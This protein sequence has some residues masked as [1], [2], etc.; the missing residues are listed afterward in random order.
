MMDYGRKEEVCKCGWGKFRREILKELLLEYSPL[1]MLEIPLSD[2]IAKV[3]SAPNEKAGTGNRACSEKSL[4]EL[5]CFR[6]TLRGKLN[7]A[8]EDAV[9]SI[10]DVKD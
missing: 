6:A 5:P 1:A 4:H 7:D 9:T 10:S 3:E 2:I 8:K